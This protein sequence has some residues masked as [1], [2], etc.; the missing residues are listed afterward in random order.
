MI[1]AVF[2][3]EAI[4][5]LISLNQKIDMNKIFKRFVLFVRQKNSFLFVHHSKAEIKY[6]LL[7]FF[8]ALSRLD[9]FPLKQ[10]QF[11]CF[12]SKHG[13]LFCAG[14][15]AKVDTVFACRTAFIKLKG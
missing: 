6:N 15:F 3:F 11:C 5:P 14:C 2:A 12:N 4:C 8:I 10:L 7:I 9:V 1:E 13:D